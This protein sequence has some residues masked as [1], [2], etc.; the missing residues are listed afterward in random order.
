MN[1]SIVKVNEIS[2]LF[3]AQSNATTFIKSGKTLFVF[4]PWLIGKVFNGAWSPLPE[5]DIDSWTSL[6]HSMDKV[7]IFISHIHED[8][9]SL[10]TLKKLPKKSR[11]YLPKFYPNFIMKN[12]LLDLGFQDVNY[13]EENELI[14]S[15]DMTI[16]VIAPL[17]FGVDLSK[18]TSKNNPKVS[19]YSSYA[20]TGALV[21]VNNSN[22]NYWYAIL[23]DNSP[24]AS[25][26][27]FPS[28]AYEMNNFRFLFF[29]FNGFA[30]DYP[31]KYINFTAKEKKEIS[32]SMAEKREKKIFDFIEVNEPNYLI[33]HSSDFMSNNIEKSEISNTFPAV[34]FERAKYVERLKSMGKNAIITSGS[35]YLIPSEKGLKSDFLDNNFTAVKDKLFASESLDF[36]HIFPKLNPDQLRIPI[37]DCIKMALAKVTE[38]ID[39]YKLSKANDFQFFIYCNNKL[40]NIDLINGTSSLQNIRP[41]SSSKYL[42]AHCSELKLKLLLFRKIHWD[43]MMIGCHIEWE[44]HP[45]KEYPQNL[46]SCLMY[47]HL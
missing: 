40:F 26:R 21:K 31:I 27:I 23:G 47:F 28:E 13:I 39:Q 1:K 43:N 22:I 7:I 5:S 38:R 37:E 16:S 36:K 12:T 34:F 10:E 30:D 41:K 45:V 17:N 25:K 44:R 32:N 4:D 20:D 11:I 6:A 19:D 18:E 33:P 2:H 35:E 42:I 9:W 3:S 29:A 14:V 15:K 24:Y 8:H 46:M